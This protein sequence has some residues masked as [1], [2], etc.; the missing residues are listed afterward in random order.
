MEEQEITALDTKWLQNEKKCIKKD[1]NDLTFPSFS[2][3][4]AE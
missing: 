3:P 1:E 2:F 4:K